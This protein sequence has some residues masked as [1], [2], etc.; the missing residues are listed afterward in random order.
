MIDLVHVQHT[1][2]VHASATV[3]A[4]DHGFLVNGIVLHLLKDTLWYDSGC[5]GIVSNCHHVR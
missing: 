4:S 2:G 3:D 5:E 1:N